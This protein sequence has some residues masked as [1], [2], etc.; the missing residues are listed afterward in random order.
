MLFQQLM[1]FAQLNYVTLW[2]RLYAIEHS[3]GGMILAF[4]GQG[5]TGCYLL[6]ML[7]RICQPP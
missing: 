5:H 3:N 7:T 1:I 2:F 4:Q 6:K